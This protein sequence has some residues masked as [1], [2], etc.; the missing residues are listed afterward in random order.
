MCNDNKLTSLKGG[1][2]RVKGNYD[3]SHNKLTSLEGS[4]ETI[5]GSWIISNIDSFGGI[6][7]VK[8]ISRVK[9]KIQEW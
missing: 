2:K 1:P 9:G 7:K 4:P 8:K 6:D 3:C 5:G